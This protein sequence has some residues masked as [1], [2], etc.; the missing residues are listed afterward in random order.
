M[1][2]ERKVVGYLSMR[3]KYGTLITLSLEQEELDE[4]KSF[5][6]D[7]LIVDGKLTTILKSRLGTLD[8]N[9]IVNLDF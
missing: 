2:D 7:K 3:M 8:P 9:E 4:L 1:K 5:E 6:N